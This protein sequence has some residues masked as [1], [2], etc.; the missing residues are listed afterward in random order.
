MRE[1]PQFTPA[2]SNMIALVPAR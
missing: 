2:R 1:T